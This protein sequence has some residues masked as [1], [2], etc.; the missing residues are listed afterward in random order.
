[1]LWVALAAHPVGDYGPESD[2]YGGYAEGARALRAGIVDPHRYVI[3]GPV[4]EAVLA[5]TSFV[6]PD[7]FTA[8]KLIS[9]AAATGAGALWLL[10]LSRRLGPGPAAWSLAFLVVLP[11]FVRYAAVASTDMLEVFFQAACLFALLGSRSKRAPLAAGVLAGLAALTRYSGLAL[12]PAIAFV[13]LRATPDARARNR[14]LS[15]SAAG[16]LAI[17]V[18]WLAVSLSHGVVPGEGLARGYAFYAR[19]GGAWNVQDALREDDAHSTRIPGAGEVIA[20][21]PLGFLAGRLREIPEHLRGDARDLLGWPAAAALLIGAW[22]L[23]QHPRRRGLV[24]LAVAGALCFVA[25]LASF[26][27]ARYSLPMALFYSV[28][29][30]GLAPVDHARGRP[31]HHRLVTA[32]GVVAACLTLVVAVQA[33]RV[34]LREAPREVVAA[35][36]ALERV[37]E[38]GAS[39]IGRK[40]HIGYYSKRRVVPFPRVRTLSELADHARRTQARFLYFTWFEIRVRPELAYLLDT[41]AAIPGL[42]VVYAS[43]SKPAVLYRIG[44]GFGRPPDFATSEFQTAVHAARATVMVRGDD[45]PAG[46]RATLAVDALLRGLWAEA[47]DQARRARRLD[48]GKGIAWAV[49]G[50]ALRRMS[51]YDE[52]RA[53]YLEAIQ[54]DPADPAAKIGLG[55]IELASGNPGEAVRLWRAAAHAADDER[56]LREISA[57]LQGAAD[58]TGARDVR[59]LM[60]RHAK[61]DAPLVPASRRD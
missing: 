11:G 47:L 22:R 1:M 30:A 31:W 36:R 25:L 59:R 4:Y 3:V 56:T 27:S 61:A 41:T 60:E 33:Q 7:P 21:D 2:F 38:P 15:L 39:V 51:R 28:A 55:R 29:A 57:L 52:A 45:A 17:A 14:A 24:P 23:R 49:E 50:E 48:P 35:G 18:P 43:A 46:D 53:A 44:P 9:V 8:A 34:A 26:H 12:L 40:G 32:I 5:L 19:Q 42:T 10:L 16:F 20:T 6:V 54:L 58:T 37:A 13:H